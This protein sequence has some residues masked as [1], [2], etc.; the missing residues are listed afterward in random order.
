MK[1][2][3]DL[4]ILMV[5]PDF[6]TESGKVSGGVQAAS[7]YLCKKLIQKFNIRLLVIKALK[8]SYNDFYELDGIP[9]HCI[10]TEGFSFP[11][12]NPTLFKKLLLITQDYNP[13]LLHFQGM[14]YWAKRCFY[15][16]LL[17]IHGILEKDVRYENSKMTGMIKYYFYRVIDGHARDRV[18]NIIVI[19]PY[20]KEFI[21]RKNQFHRFWEINNP[22]DEIF[23]N[24][25]RSPIKYR[26]FTA[27]TITKRKNIISLIMAFKPIADEQPCAELRIAGAEVDPHYYQQVKLV[28][29]SLGLEN[30]VKL[31][32]NLSVKEIAYELSTCH[33][34]LIC[35]LQETAP[36]AIAEAMAG[37]VPVVASNVGGIPYMI[38]DDVNGVLVNP[39]DMDSIVNGVRKIIYNDSYSNYLS[40]NAQLAAGKY[41]I[42]YI[43][44]RTK[45]AYQEIKLSLKTRGNK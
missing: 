8:K 6:P 26:I 21:R 13:D 17:T 28:I 7:Y 14:A 38:T 23:F 4:C 10:N 45:D 42:D 24:T 44:E 30:N 40:K 36:I 43:A 18:K 9:I 11:Y 27:S 41:H 12:L 5:V 1:N 32:G 20:V 34:F 25:T 16:N 31:L 35:S 19:N 33:C 2:A 37:G 39:S 22:V 3:N 29:K 15:P